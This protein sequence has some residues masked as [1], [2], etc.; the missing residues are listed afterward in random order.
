MP[1][2]TELL[3]RKCRV[4]AQGIRVPETTW[5]YLLTGDALL[6]R[7]MRSGTSGG[8]HLTFGPGVTVDCPVSEAFALDSPLELR[9]EAGRYV[10][11]G[12]DGDW[13]VVTVP[14]PSWY[15]VFQSGASPS[16]DADGEAVNRRTPAASVSDP[17]QANHG[18]T[19]RSLGQVCG[20][21]LTISIASHCALFAEPRLR[22]SF[23]SI[24]FNQRRE[25][26]RRPDSAL[27]AMIALAIAD[28]AHPVRHLMIGG[29]TRDLKDLSYGP[30]IEMA[31]GISARFPDLPLSAMMV[32]PTDDAQ[33]E[34]LRAVGVDEIAINIELWSD[35]AI[36]AHIPGKHALF[37]R[38]GYLRTLA[39]AVKVFGPRRVRSLVVVGLEPMTETLRAVEALA[40]IGVVPVLSPLRPLRQ[41]A[42][43]G[44][45]PPSTRD[46]LAL[47]EAALAIC[48]RYDACLGP[49]C[50]G[51][52]GNTLTIHGLSDLVPGS[53]RSGI[54]KSGD[55]GEYPGRVDKG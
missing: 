24:G 13:P 40:E 1:N 8:L 21:R 28:P 35:T 30:A 31:R 4:L 48:H 50:A 2:L 7:R 3:Y 26:P 33:L 11:A 23:C 37:G 46:L 6:P 51:C 10:I 44:Y 27:H 43:E 15:D 18:G 54:D 34:R 17:A 16:A 47:H 52:Q 14:R 41:T 25:E 42:L 9:C 5:Q 49:L 29:G 38:T 22:C 12:P 53:S 36:A 39:R 45:S 32:P 20:D 19:A 55:R